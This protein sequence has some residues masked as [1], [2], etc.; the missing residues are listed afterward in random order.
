M[1]IIT[2]SSAT[3]ITSIKV[4][5]GF[6]FAVLGSIKGIVQI[7]REAQRIIVGRQ[8][9][10]RPSPGTIECLLYLLLE[11]QVVIGS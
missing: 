4:T 11:P 8:H 3:P 2:I 5:W 6:P 7:L 1:R 9:L 10:S